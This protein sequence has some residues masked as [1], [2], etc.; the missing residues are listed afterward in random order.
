LTPE[1]R[2]ELESLER[3]LYAKVRFEARSGI[4]PEIV[5]LGMRIGSLYFKAGSRKF[6]DFARNLVARVGQEVKPYLKS[7]WR[8]RDSSS[9]RS[10]GVRADRNPDATSG[11]ADATFGVASPDDGFTPDD[12]LGVVWFWFADGAGVVAVDADGAADGA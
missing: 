10:S 2:A 1:E 6:A 11:V 8:S 5:S 12:N 3:Q 7:I 9:A 4:D